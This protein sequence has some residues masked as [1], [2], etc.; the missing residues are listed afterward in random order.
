MSFLSVLHVGLSEL[1][2]LILVENLFCG[3]G[4]EGCSFS[5][6]LKSQNVTVLFF[7]SVMYLSLAKNYIY[8]KMGL[9]TLPFNSFVVIAFFLRTLIVS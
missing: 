4:G 3:G 7:M 1:K 6:K 2:C 5:F 8:R 9:S